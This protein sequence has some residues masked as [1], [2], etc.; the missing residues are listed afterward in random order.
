MINIKKMDPW[1]SW[2]PLGRGWVEAG[3]NWVS[4]PGLGTGQEGPGYMKE[5]WADCA[6]TP[7]TLRRDAATKDTNDDYEHD[8]RPDDC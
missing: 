8:E 7:R 2:E 5:R 6:W 4:L 3:L 1:E